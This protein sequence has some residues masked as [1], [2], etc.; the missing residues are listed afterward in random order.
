MK[1]VEDA[2]TLIAAV[3]LTA[4]AVFGIGV[5]IGLSSWSLM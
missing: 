2:G 3:L 4:A 5:L 1:T